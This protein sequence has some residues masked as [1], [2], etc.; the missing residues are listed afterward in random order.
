MAVEI[1][2]KLISEF[3]LVWPEHPSKK[4]YDNQK[5]I[6]NKELYLIPWNIGLNIFNILIINQL[7][8]VEI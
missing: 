5:K 4:H 8:F 6:A 7:L 1:F 3:T 2:L